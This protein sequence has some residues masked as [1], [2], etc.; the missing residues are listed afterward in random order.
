MDTLFYPGSVKNTGLVL[1]NF[2]ENLDFLDTEIWQQSS[3]CNN[4]L[5]WWVTFDDWLHHKAHSQNFSLKLGSLLRL[6]EVDQRQKLF[7]TD[8][9]FI[10]PDEL[11]L[12][13]SEHNLALKFFPRIP[14]F[15]V[16]PRPLT[17]HFMSLRCG[18]VNAL[19]V[20]SCKII[21]RQW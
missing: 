16:H 1:E 3:S 15:M 21:K 20:E 17:F 11:C 12:L 2:L 19:Y 14:G 6:K 7:P 4:V 5:I 8:S 9:V 13:L 10:N 18:W